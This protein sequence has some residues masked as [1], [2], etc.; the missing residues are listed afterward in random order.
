MDQDQTHSF[1]ASTSKCWEWPEAIL[2]DTLI[3]FNS[4]V[5]VFLPFSNCDNKVDL[6]L[7]LTEWVEKGIWWFMEDRSTGSYRTR[8]SLSGKPRK[9]PSNRL[10][11]HGNNARED[12]SVT[13]LIPHLFPKTCYRLLPK[14]GPRWTCSPN[15]YISLVLNKGTCISSRK[16]FCQGIYVSYHAHIYMY[17]YSWMKP[18]KLL[19]NCGS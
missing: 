18:A 1:L 2:Q 9:S 12:C 14:R 4:S 17:G 10:L 7:A 3:M 15:L 11:E 16:D 19:M 13:L 8:W 6:T 5:A